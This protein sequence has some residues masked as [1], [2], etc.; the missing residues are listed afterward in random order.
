MENILAAMIAG[1]AHGLGFEEMLKAIA[2]YEPPT[3]RCELVRCW[4]GREFINDS[5][6][7]NLHALEACIASLDG[8]IILIAGGKEKGLDY[9][10]LRASIQDH[11]KGMVCI[12]EI[13][14]ALAKTFGDLVP[15]SI[16]ATLE[17]AVADAAARSVAGDSI[18]LSPG[19]SSF[20]MFTGYAQRGEVY[21]RAVMA[22][23]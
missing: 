3:H 2:T 6:A 9:T 21:R 1:Q 14:P 18:V 7:T 15:C 5:K 22:L 11:V 20:D 19:T 17:D 10:A 23:G 16:A 12:G 8:P 4:Q 13:G